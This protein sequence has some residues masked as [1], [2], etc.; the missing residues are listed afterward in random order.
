MAQ[1]KREAAAVEVLDLLVEAGLHNMRTGRLARW[2][3]A[4]LPSLSWDFRT[5][6]AS[7][8]AMTEAATASQVCVDSARLRAGL[9][10]IGP[11]SAFEAGPPLVA[12]GSTHHVSVRTADLRRTAR[13][14][15]SRRASPG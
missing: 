11:E 12:V 13:R 8:G 7:P 2:T 14:T 6:S 3:G 1:A 10:L 9:P 4:E 15:N 5:K